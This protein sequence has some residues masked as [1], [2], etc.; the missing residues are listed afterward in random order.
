[1]ATRW[2][3]IRAEPVAARVPTAA[4]ESPLDMS[5]RSSTLSLCCRK[6][7]EAGS[8]CIQ[9]EVKCHASRELLDQSH[10][11]VTVRLSRALQRDQVQAA[12]PTA[13]SLERVQRAWKEP[14][15]RS[16]F[17]PSEAV[18]SGQQFCASPREEPAQVSLLRPSFLHALQ[19]DSDV[20]ATCRA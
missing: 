5:R 15:M 1:M 4:V 3:A 8:R 12:P 10:T 14:R 18:A 6:S 11:I 7:C 20:R 2:A 17:N 16:A 9:P 19:R 13:G